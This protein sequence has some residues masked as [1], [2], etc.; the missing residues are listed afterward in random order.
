MFVQNT[1]VRQ[2]C[3][4]FAKAVARFDR[5]LSDFIVLRAP[6]PGGVAITLRHGSTK[7]DIE[8]ARNEQS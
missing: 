7:A 8:V 5:F 1:L 2:T 4:L 3:R 6:R